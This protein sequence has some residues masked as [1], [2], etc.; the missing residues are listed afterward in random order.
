MQLMCDFFSCKI[1][2]VLYSGILSYVKSDFKSIFTSF[3][4]FIT[5]HT[6]R[7]SL[8]MFYYSTD[9]SFGLLMMLENKYVNQFNRGENKQCDPFNIVDLFTFRNDVK[10]SN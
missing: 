8:I 3:K 6:V 2:G 7:N 4:V 1:G 10:Q 9:L 5:L